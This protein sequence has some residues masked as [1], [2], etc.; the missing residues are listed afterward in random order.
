[1]IVIYLIIG[2]IALYVLFALHNFLRLPTYNK[3]YNMWQEDVEKVN[4]A[5]IA[6]IM[7]CMISFVM[8]VISV[9]MIN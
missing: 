1:M 3:V 5:N 6:I 2:L 8:G 9:L 4:K 7:M